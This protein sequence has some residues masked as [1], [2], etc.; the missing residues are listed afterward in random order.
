MVIAFDFDGTLDTPYVKQLAKKF[1]R[2]NEIWVVTARNENDFNREKLRST[3]N[4]LMLTDLSV[5][6]CNER[7]KWEVLMA[8]NADMYIDNITD[9]FYN[10][11][12]HTN[13]IPLLWCNL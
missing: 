4:E 11:L 12:K 6:Y 2:N 7:P 8:I 13:T 3:L 10:I 5:I 1:R 9:E